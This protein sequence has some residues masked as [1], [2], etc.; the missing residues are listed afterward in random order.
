MVSTSEWKNKLSLAVSF[1][2]FHTQVV[3]TFKYDLIELVLFLKN[4][5]V[6]YS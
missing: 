6:N 4:I 1:P 2:L 3:N 5:R